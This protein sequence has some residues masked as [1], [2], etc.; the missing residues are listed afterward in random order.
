MDAR[1]WSLVGRLW[2]RHRWSLP[3]SI[4]SAIFFARLASEMREGEVD[5][6]DRAVQRLVDA[7]RGPLDGIMLAFTK[8]GGIAPMSALTAG[9]FVA[10]LA[11]GHRREARYL[12][13]SAAGALLLNVVLKAAIHRARPDE[14]LAYMLP[15]PSSLSFP[16]GHTMGST[17]VVMSLIVVLH[18]LDTPKRLRWLAICLGSVAIGGVGMSRVYFGVH[19]PS[20]VLGGLLAAA[21]WVSGFTGWMYPHLL[22]GE[23]TT[24]EGGA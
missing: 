15:S 16:S 12:V 22:P 23:S 6:F 8:G 20:D 1:R 4:G 9:A 3:L 21:A 19:Y 7:W 13:V 17:G 5:G 11:R 2:R 24:V 14:A 18:A 10:L